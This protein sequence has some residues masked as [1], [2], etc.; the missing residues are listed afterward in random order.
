MGQHGSPHDIANTQ[1]SW[2][3]GFEVV[4]DDDSSFLIE[5]EGKLI[6]LD[7]IFSQYAAP[8]PWLGR[9][10]YSSKLPITINQLPEVDFV[11]VS[12]DHYDHLDSN[13]L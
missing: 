6:L 11:V 4:I 8:H 5:L 13:S 12:H 10:R 9:P 2:D 7:P 3:V 1:N